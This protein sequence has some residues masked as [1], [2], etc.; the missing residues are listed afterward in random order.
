MEDATFIRCS[1]LARSLGSAAIH[2]APPPVALLDPYNGGL[3]VARSLV[4][5]GT[6]VAVLAGTSDGFIARSR[7]VDGEVVPASEPARRQAA[8]ER[9]AERGFRGVLTGGDAASEWLALERERL[10]AS[11][12]TFERDDDGHVPLM[13][14]A[15]ADVIARRAGVPVPWTRPAGTIGELDRAVRE[16]PYPA[17]LK[18]VLSHAWRAV[19][20]DDRVLLV[21][22]EALARAQGER[23]LAADLPMVMSEYIPGGDDDVEEAIVVRAPDGSYPVAFGCHK[24]RQFPVGFGAASLCEIADLPESMALARAVLDEA[25]FVGVA[26]VETKRHAGSGVHYFLEVNVRIPTQFGLGDAAGLDASRRMARM[27]L[28]HDVGPQPPV[29]RRARLLFPQQEVRAARAALRAA[30]AGER[31]ATAHRL[32]RSYAGVRDLGILDPRDP[33]P[34]VALVGQVLRRRLQR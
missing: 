22:G 2:G 4:R 26:G 15:T 14:K 12:A 13:G 32:L 31:L 6:R 28:G 30:P 17:V 3:S 7:G 23:A 8:L 9:L 25:G 5:S 34:G 20:G 19:F 16:A 10:P 24:I 21:H 29:R 11:L 27:L 1:K 18:P 33:G